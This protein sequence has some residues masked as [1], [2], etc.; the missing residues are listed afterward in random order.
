MVEDMLGGP[1]EVFSTCPPIRGEGGAYLQKV[2]DVAR[3]SEQS[4]CRGMLVYADNSLLDPWLVSQAIVENTEALCPLVAVQPVY[5]HPYTVAKL[6]AT[7]GFLYCRR[8]YLNMV[9][10]G[11]KNDL[12]ALND[13][14]PHDQRYERL[15]EY[16]MVIK[17]LLIGTG[18]VTFEGRFYKVDKLKMVPPLSPDLLPGI[19]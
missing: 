7:L 17:Q 8:L 3:W 12:H 14:T 16:T 15:V 1:I 19:T 6:V 18:P 4:G 13:P 5:M 11:F 2:A 10:G 9:A